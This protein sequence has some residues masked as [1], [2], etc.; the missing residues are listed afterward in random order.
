MRPTNHPSGLSVQFQVAA[1]CL[2]LMYMASVPFSFA[3]ALLDGGHGA[4]LI[5]GFT[6][7]AVAWMLARQDIGGPWWRRAPRVFGALLLVPAAAALFG[8]SIHEEQAS[9]RRQREAR[10]EA[11]FAALRAQE[12]AWRAR[13]AEEA[14]R[15]SAEERVA[16]LAESRRSPGE[17]ATLIRG[18][19]AGEG[20]AGALA[21]QERVC[22]ARRQ[23]ERIPAA[24]RGQTDVREALRLLARAEREALAE[25]REAVRESR[26]VRCCD[27]MLSPS[28][29]CRRPSHRGC[30]SHHGG[31]CGCEELPTE[32][33]CSSR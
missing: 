16:V 1:T 33:F 27:G 29:R 6:G 26:M 5:V 25:E 9:E 23:A 20:D 15:R 31:M 21:L 13:R 11:D 32:I 14:A 24:A 3:V 30:C 12:T 22:R 7:V 28:C 8:R 4:M 18:L 19:A 17:R 10:S 2:L